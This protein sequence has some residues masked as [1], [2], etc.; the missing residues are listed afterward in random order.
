MKF[1]NIKQFFPEDLTAKNVMRDLTLS[2]ASKRKSA[3]TYDRPNSAL[4]ELFTA[5]PLFLTALM[6]V[7][8]NI[9]C[10]WNQEI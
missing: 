8:R 9:I 10:Y 6:I 1:Q 5:L 4:A 2:A 3:R 7:Y